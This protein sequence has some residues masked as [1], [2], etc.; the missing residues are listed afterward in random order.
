MGKQW[1]SPVQ[2]KVEGS[3][4]NFQLEFTFN[5]KVPGIPSL[6]IPKLPRL[7]KINLFCPLD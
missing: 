7:P 6:P 3:L 4:C 2:A 5:F 1:D